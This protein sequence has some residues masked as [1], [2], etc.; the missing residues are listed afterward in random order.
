[1]TRVFIIDWSHHPAKTQAWYDRRKEQAERE[2]MQHIFAQEVDRNYSA[3]VSNTIIEYAWLQAAVDAHLTVPCLRVPPPD[4]WMGGFDVADEGFDRNA[5]VARQWVIIREAMEWGD[6]DPG[7]ST[8]R[9]I[10]A[11]NAHDGRIKVQY[12]E[13][14][15]GV[16]VKSEYNSLTVDQGVIIPPFVGWNA[17]AA[18]VNPYDNV[19]PDD[20]DSPLNRDVFGNFKAQAWWA[21][22]TAFYK[23]WRAVTHGDVYPA[24]Q[25]ISLD[26]T[27]PLLH[28]LMKELAQPTRGDSTGLRMIV[29]KK[30][31]G[32]KSPNL[33]DAA[34]MCMFPA[35][36]DSNY[37]IVGNYRI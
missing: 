20:P 1:M 8:K 33:A 29:N 30:P 24:E 21:A 13:I 22:R 17:G 37:T 28:Q 18:V 31:P 9:V 35:P 14:G 4:T 12:D 7:V 6:R 11:A 10:H 16:S 23:T 34:V 25:L 2:G 3:A 27:M 36:E 15:M 19:I 5:Y 26:S 32:T